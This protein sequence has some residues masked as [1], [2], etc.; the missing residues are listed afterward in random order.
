MKNSWT[1]RIAGVLL[2]LVMFFAGCEKQKTE[3]IVIDPPAS[4]N[5]STLRE[6]SEPQQ[7]EFP[8]SPDV[9]SGRPEPSKRQKTPSRS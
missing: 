6:K 9:E 3:E 4:Q 8:A 7:S 1:C 2:G 5:P